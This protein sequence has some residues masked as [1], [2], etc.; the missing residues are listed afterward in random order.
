MLRTNVH[1]AYN[2]YKTPEGVYLET[3]K[4]HIEGLS[5]RVNVLK[6]ELES[7]HPANLVIDDATPRGY[8]DNNPIHVAY[9]QTKE[10]P[11]MQRELISSKQLNNVG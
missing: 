1:N 5:A 6:L 7:I 9:E 11:V 10:Y 4:Q 8:G 3:P 2:A